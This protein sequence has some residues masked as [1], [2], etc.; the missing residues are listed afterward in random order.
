MNKLGSCNV[1]IDFCI[2]PA[3]DH[4]LKFYGQQSSAALAK[5]T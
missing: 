4:L 3:L 2:I 5:G 1:P